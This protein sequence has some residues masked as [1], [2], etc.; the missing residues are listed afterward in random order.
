MEFGVCV[1]MGYC[2]HR[3][4]FLSK[5]VEFLDGVY[6]GLGRVVDLVGGY[7][8]GFNELKDGV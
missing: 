2:G 6:N 8:C 7:L 1:G 5:E 3:P 4:Y